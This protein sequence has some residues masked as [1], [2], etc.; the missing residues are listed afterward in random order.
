MI[1]ND[2]L[3]QIYVLKYFLLFMQYNDLYHSFL[4]EPDSIYSSALYGHQI[5]LTL[6]FLDI[7]VHFG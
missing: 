5:C 1:E 7:L 4:L 2:I 6:W 3:I